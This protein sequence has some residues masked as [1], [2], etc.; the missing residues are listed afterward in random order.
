MRSKI[1]V[2]NPKLRAQLAEAPGPGRAPRIELGRSQ[3]GHDERTTAKL[4]SCFA[5][6]FRGRR[7]PGP[8]SRVVHKDLS[9]PDRPAKI[10]ADLQAKHHALFGGWDDLEKDVALEEFVLR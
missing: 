4:T 3:G 7:S 10:S 2:L 9:S 1:A 8:Q 6:V 5:V